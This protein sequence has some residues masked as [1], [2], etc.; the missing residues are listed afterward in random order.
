MSKFIAVNPK[1]IRYLAMYSS[2]ELPFE[3]A[4]KIMRF[5]LKIMGTFVEKKMKVLG[6]VDKNQESEATEKS[7]K[8][9]SAKK[10]ASE[11]ET[12]SD[13]GN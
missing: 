9:K 4:V 1:A 5:V 13:E 8:S 2:K 7:S 10:A 6:D 3:E 12:T 11:T